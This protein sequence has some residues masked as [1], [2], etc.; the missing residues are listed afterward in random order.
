[1]KGGGAF[2][3]KD[4][5]KADYSIPLYLNHLAR[6][7]GY[8]DIELKAHTI[9]GD[10]EVVISIKSEHKSNSKNIKKPFS[11]IM[12]FAEKNPMDWTGL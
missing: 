7:T 5:S 11:E 8:G 6:N 1:M 2:F 4:V 12:E 10:D 9:I 3:G